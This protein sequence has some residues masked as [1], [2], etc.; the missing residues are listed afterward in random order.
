MVNKPLKRH[1][2]LQPLSREHHFALLLCLKLRQGLEL[3]ID[4]N[5]I[6]AYLVKMW[7]HQLAL[8]FDI[9]ERFVF[10]ILGEDHAYVKEAISDHRLLKRLILKEPFTIKSI[11]RIEERLENHVRFEERKLFPLVQ[12]VASD[13]QWQIVEQEHDKAIPELMWHDAFWVK[14]VRKEIKT[15]EEISF[16]VDTFYQRVQSD[17][18]IGPIFN[19][20]LDGRWEEHLKKMYTFWQTLLLEEHTYFG[21]PF[22]PHATM[23]ISAAHFQAWLSIW[24]STVYEFFKGDKADEAVYRGEKMAQ[25]FL[26]KIKYFKNQNN[27][28]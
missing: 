24:K 23:P 11:N 25:V 1:P 17:E 21:S 10:P 14:P 27:T 18:L 5:R 4:P 28:H 9:E 22:P 26:S 20:L 7:E 3:E 12:S 6:G 19:E 15:L 13:L 8:H 2:A 16:L